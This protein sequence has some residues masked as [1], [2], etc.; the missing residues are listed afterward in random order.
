MLLTATSEIQKPAVL[1]VTQSLV[2]HL[3][4]NLKSAI[5]KADDAEAEAALVKQQVCGLRAGFPISE[6]IQ[7]L[8]LTRASGRGLCPG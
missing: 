8:T 2:D 3:N 5:D 1:Q 7:A 4:A 6:A